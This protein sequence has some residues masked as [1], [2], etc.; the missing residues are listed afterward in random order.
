MKPGYVISA[1]NV[2]SIFSVPLLFGEQK[3]HEI[4]AERLNLGKVELNL[5]KWIGLN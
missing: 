4:I 2:K 1:H 5:T 3:F